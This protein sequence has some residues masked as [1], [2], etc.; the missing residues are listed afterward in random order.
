MV[1][2]RVWCDATVDAGC[3]FWEH[4]HSLSEVKG[5]WI[6]PRLWRLVYESLRFPIIVTT[7]SVCVC[8]C[9][10]VCLGVNHY[11]IIRWS[12]KVDEGLPCV[13]HYIPGQVEATLRTLSVSQRLFLLWSSKQDI[14]RAS[15][16]DLVLRGGS[17]GRSDLGMDHVDW[18]I[19]WER[20]DSQNVDEQ[21]ERHLFYCWFPSYLGKLFDVGKSRQLVCVMVERHE[22]FH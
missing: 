17:L 19:A 11:N 9:V 12:I 7:C 16:G 18:G 4:L 15:K 6:V 22:L 14:R 8:V 13:R 3:G 5:L 20:G 21:E 10:C 1:F 2:V